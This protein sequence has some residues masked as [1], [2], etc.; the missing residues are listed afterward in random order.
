MK[1]LTLA[2]LL[3]LAMAL[4]AAA[5][6]Y[7]DIDV[8]LPAYPDMQQ[9]PESPVYYAPYVDSNYFF[10]DGLY[11]DFCND[12]WYSSPWYN[13]PWTLVDPVYVPTYVLWVPIRFYH[14]P[15]DYFRSW[16]VH[17]P[18]LW[19][20]RWG[21]DWQRRHNEIYRRVT[22]APAYTPAPLPH[23]QRQFP[24][25]SYPRGAQ[26][27]II[28]SQQYGYVPRESIGR[29]QYQARGIPTQGIQR[30]QVVQGQPPQ[31]QWDGRG[32]APR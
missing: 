18:P 26:Q 27:S 32:G 19:G 7:Y 25:E 11:W 24:R 10:Y 22:T 23:Y 21:R 16:N 29:Q 6:E 17:R 4:P 31:H 30:P 3:L 1:R 14:R 15:P 5:Q 8:D 20:Q 2:L 28:H 9:V 13:G 12:A